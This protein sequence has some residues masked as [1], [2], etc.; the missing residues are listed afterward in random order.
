M[1]AFEIGASR[2]SYHGVGLHVTNGTAFIA[3]RS[4]QGVPNNL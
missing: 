1:A 2:R 3:Y 4:C